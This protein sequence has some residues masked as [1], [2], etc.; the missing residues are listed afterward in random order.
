M[1]DSE[2][3]QL[4]RI[5]GPGR[6]EVLE[7]ATLDDIVEL[8]VGENLNLI[9]LNLIF[10]TGLQ[11]PY[12]SFLVVMGD[13]AEEDMDLPGYTSGESGSLIYQ[14]KQIVEY[15]RD[16]DNASC[17]E[18]SDLSCDKGRIS[19]INKVDAN[20]RFPHHYYVEVGSDSCLLPRYELITLFYQFF[21][22]NMNMDA[23][24]SDAQLLVGK[25]V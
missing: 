22:R 11:H 17:T 10:R 6:L 15:I 21:G 24:E 1:S 12:E 4:R 13:D 25:P 2:K 16:S 9:G 14:N 20:D 7:G 8:R 18:F 5:V 19:K 3:P 23:F